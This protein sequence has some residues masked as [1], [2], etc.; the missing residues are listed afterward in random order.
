MKLLEPATKFLFFTGKGGVGK[1][2]LACATEVQFADAGRRALLVSS[3]PASNLDEMLAV[4][5]S[6][7]PTPVPGVPNLLALNI[8]PEQAAESYRQRVVGAYVPTWSEQQLS[9]L[10][11]QLS[12]SCTVEI[13]AFDEFAGLL[14]GEDA[15]AG[16]AHIVFDT[17]P[18]GHTLRLRLLRPR[19]Q[20]LPPRP[21]V[22]GE[23][24]RRVRFL[25]SRALVRRRR[26]GGLRHLRTIAGGP[27]GS[28]CPRL[29]Q[30]RRP[31]P[32]RR[33]SVR[34]GGWSGAGGGAGGKRIGMAP[35][36]KAEERR[37]Q[38]QADGGRED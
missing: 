19:H 10:R 28:V 18:T 34:G 30:W 25:R 23:L 24:L 7:R 32:A 29:R 36:R 5:L 13:A 8:D 1:T 2:A 21:P 37:H 26:P 33:R 11:E 9:E 3:D 4:S 38:E 17:A 6:D 20:C 16:F 15:A 22:W 27:T 31:S 35:E 12:G 14:A